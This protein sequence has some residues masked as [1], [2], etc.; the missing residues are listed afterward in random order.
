MASS[1][2]ELKHFM[3]FNTF[4]STKFLESRKMDNLQFPVGKWLPSC[5]AAFKIFQTHMHLHRAQNVSHM[6]KIAMRFQ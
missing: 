2:T 4:M 3:I 6:Y 5:Y 1:T